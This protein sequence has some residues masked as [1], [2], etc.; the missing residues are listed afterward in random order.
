MQTFCA[1]AAQTASLTVGSVNLTVKNTCCKPI[2]QGLTRR[3]QKF[4]RLFPSRGFDKPAR[5]Y[6]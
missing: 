2:Y 5:L 6:C 3:L 1:D 4:I